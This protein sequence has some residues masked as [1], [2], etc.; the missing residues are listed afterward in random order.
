MICASGLFSNISAAYWA[1]L[2]DVSEKSSGTIILIII[3]EVLF[4]M[5]LKNVSEGKIY[6]LKKENICSNFASQ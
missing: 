3:I 6:I 4:A 1:A 5:L 2:K